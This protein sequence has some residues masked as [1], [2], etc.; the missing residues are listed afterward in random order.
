MIKVFKR[1]MFSNSNSALLM[2]FG[3]LSMSSLSLV[4]CGTASKSITMLPE[5]SGKNECVILVHGLGRTYRSMNKI[6][7]RLVQEGY[8]T[9]NLD[10]PSRKYS[11]EQLASR[12]IPAAINE[13]N[14]HNPA[15]IH[16]VTHSLGGIVVRMAIKKNRPENLG[17]VVM[18]SP[19]NQGS[20]AV[21]NLKDKWYFS[22]ING[23][24]GQELSTSEDSTPNQLGSVDYPVGII[25]GDRHSYFDDWL[26]VFFN[27][28]NDGKVSVE[29]AKLDGM[30]DFIVVHE[31]HPYI[32]K[33]EY[34]QSQTIE[35][36]RNEF[37][38]HETSM[39]Y[40]DGPP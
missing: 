36:L 18:L 1:M 8:H 38:S 3:I 34:V 9:V 21:D 40:N 28:A 33:S 7:R 23:P 2:L 13:C 10:Y 30:K 11:I 24:A 16:F 26:L 25:M 29:R 37:F 12:Y 39:L 32:M 20:E 22:L 31:S 15:R 35:F 27:G 17:R 4:G 5:D 19:P 14:G 6:Q